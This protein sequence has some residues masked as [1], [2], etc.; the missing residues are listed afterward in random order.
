MLIGVAIFALLHLQGP[1]RDEPAKLGPANKQRPL[2]SSIVNP[3]GSSTLVALHSGA[4]HQRLPGSAHVEPALNK[5]S[6][7][8]HQGAPLWLLSGAACRP[9]PQQPLASA[10]KKSR[11][12]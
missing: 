1:K 10:S 12:K 4:N 7:G 11:A 3:Y 2:T 8:D 6:A 5:Q 9:E